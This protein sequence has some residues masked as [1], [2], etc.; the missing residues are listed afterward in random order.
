MKHAVFLSSTGQDLHAHREAVRAAV[1]RLEGF[2]CLAMEDFG[3][4]AVEPA[5]LCADLVRKA[6][7]F[8]GLVGHFFGAT[9]PGDDRSFTELEYDEAGTAGIPRLMFM[10]N[11][12]FALIPKL[13][14]ENDHTR[15]QRFRGRVSLKDSRDTF[16]EPA[17]L[18]TSVTTALH[19]WERQRRQG[20][21]AIESALPPSPSFSQGFPLQSHFTGRGPERQT[22]TAW[23]ATGPAVLV[24]GG[25]GGMGK[26]SLAWVWLCHDVLGFPISGQDPTAD[27]VENPSA[28]PPGS[29]PDGAIWWSFYERPEFADFLREGLRYLSEGSEEPELLLSQADAVRLGEWLG[30]RRALV[31]LDGFERLL[32]A[33]LPEQPTQVGMQGR[34]CADPLARAFLQ[35]LVRR[36]MKSR[37]LLATRIAPREVENASC[38]KPMVLG[39]LDP[40]DA[41]RFLRS[42]GVRGS[43]EDLREAGRQWDFHPLSLR[44]L[45]GALVNDPELQGEIRYAPRI[46]LAQMST[47]SLE[48]RDTQKLTHLLRFAYD[49]LRNPADDQDDSLRELMRQIAG[50]QSAV[51]FE[52]LAGSMVPIDREALKAHLTA[53]CN[54]GLLSFNEEKR[55][56]ETHPSI[57]RYFSDKLRTRKSKHEEI[58]GHLVAARTRL[59]SSVGNQDAVDAAL[60]LFHQAVESGHLN[61]ALNEF[62]NNLFVPLF[63][64]KGAYDKC[65][66]LLLRLAPDEASEHRTSRR[67]AFEN[68]R[69][70]A[71]VL[72]ALG[73][74]YARTGNPQRSRDLLSKAVHWYSLNGDRRAM[75]VVLGNLVRTQILLG[76]LDEAEQTLQRRIGLAAGQRNSTHATWRARLADL[77]DLGLHVAGLVT[78]EEVHRVLRP[79]P[80]AREPSSE[81]DQLVE[82]GP[83]AEDRGDGLDALESGALHTLRG[84]PEHAHL[85]L[86][87]AATHLWRRPDALSTVELYRARAWLAADDPQA[88]LDSASRAG[89]LWREAAAQSL[90]HAGNAMNID[91]ALGTCHLTLAERGRAAAHI[92]KAEGYLVQALNC[93]RTI[94]YVELLPE[95]LSSWARF[96]FARGAA[97]DAI[98]HATQ[99]V[100]VSRPYPLKHTAARDVLAWIKRGACR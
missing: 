37:I 19:N 49:R 46:G 17:E 28:L 92:S 78:A 21:R 10:A 84:E 23:F 26:S 42:Q 74:V 9:V 48:D 87:R 62:E 98:E 73:V 5:V 95:A 54:R 85:A 2:D 27:R 63:F 6:D 82:S 68:S 99:A 56:Y 59:R 40:A 83:Q 41:A 29:R 60:E 35:G 89:E 51:T 34:A 44:L 30:K 13:W 24:L 71:W 93:S 45:A 25:F 12:N 36:P 97:D 81:D 31:V 79:A 3:A 91:W 96:C 94:G 33:Y 47:G 75:R 55:A 72:N 76:R 1:R 4:R 86:N 16:L 53:L 58:W 15:Q 80:A 90:P 65:K 14:A 50:F 39:G 61:K 67:H 43:E 18:A 57:R 7:V 66:E 22:L 69:D 70:R 11:E 100:N 52:R 8:V 64:R 38:C 20:V 77:V 32:E 88:A